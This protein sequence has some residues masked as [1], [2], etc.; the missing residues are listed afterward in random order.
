[1]AEDTE[2]TDWF[3]H[4]T[5]TEWFWYVKYLSAN[6]T[7]AKKNVH[8]GGP[9]ISKDALRLLFPRLEK[10]ANRV[11]NPDLTLPAEVDSHGAWDLTLRLVWYNSKRLGQKNG[12]DEAR[13]TR[14][15]D[16][17]RPWCQPGRR[18]R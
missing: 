4:V 8:Q 3:D 7:Y 15:A 14:W 6:N 12:R 10:R 13:L 5:G 18:A 9:Y 1:M 2:L 11:S 16:S 17:T